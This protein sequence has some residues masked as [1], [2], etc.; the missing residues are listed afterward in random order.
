MTVTVSARLGAFTG[1]ARAGTNVM[2]ILI[3]LGIV[4]DVVND[5]VPP[6]EYTDEYLSFVSL[7]I[8]AT[9][10][11]NSN[12]NVFIDSS[13]NALSITA[14]GTPTQGTFSPYSNTGGSIYLNGTTDY[15]T[16]PANAV[17]TLGTGDFT[18]EAWIYPTNVAT[19]AYIMSM[20]Y[21]G[22]TPSGQWAL[23]MTGAGA[24]KQF[25]FNSSA[26]NNMASTTVNLV[27]NVW[28]HVA[29]SRS[30]TSGRFFI[31]GAQ[32]GTTL[33]DSKNYPTASGTFY[34]G[35]MSTASNYFPGYIAD[36][37]VVKGTAL[38]TTTFTAPT[39]PLTPV[40]NTSLLLSGT[41]AAIV[42][43]LDKNNLVLVGG[44]KVSTTQVKYD[45]GSVAFDGN[46]DYVSLPLTQSMQLGADN[47]TY[48]LWVYTNA[49]GLRQSIAYINSNSSGFAALSVNIL[50]NGK[51]ACAMSESGS[52]WKFEDLTGL[53]TAL[54]I[55]TWYHVAVVRNGATIT[56]YLNG[57]SIGTYSLTSSLTSLMTTY[58]L[59]QVGAYNTSYYYMNGYLEDVR[60]TKGIARYLS[61]FTPPDTS[62]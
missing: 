34:V 13:S 27:P 62:F 37:R 38:Y 61:N 52:A 2:G 53:G 5:V 9:G 44:A 45:T 26:G 42:D 17:F 49:I 15:L 58:T 16:T 30:G 24:S 57:T 47:F 8:K 21:E 29:Y 56:M 41:N 1:A 31:N 3:S 54:S 18:V 28:T 23:Y 59:N 25:W 14:N 10:A 12:N 33:T 4:T 11:N 48:E 19:T 22:T 39:A 7:L 20:N 43:A 6:V 55:N 32:L 50:A 36:A 51:L 35:R 46:G 40:T 60:L